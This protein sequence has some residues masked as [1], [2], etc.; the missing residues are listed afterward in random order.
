MAKPRVFVSSTYYDLKHVRTDLEH[1]IKKQGFEPVLHERGDIPYGSKESLE[2]YCYKEIELC[3]ILVSIIGGRFG[4][5][6]KKQDYSISNFELK[7]AIEM[8]KQ[9]YI[10]VYKD[11]FSEYQTYKIN[12]D[13]KGINY[14]AVDDPRTYTFLE[15]VNSLSL[16]NQI[17]EFDGVEDITLHLKAQWA[18]LFHRLLS[19]SMR[20][21]EIDLV[22]DLKNTS[23]T[24]K[25]LAEYL[26][27]EKEKGTQAVKDILLINHPAFREIQKTLE[28]PYRIVFQNINELSQHLK[29]IQ[30]DEEYSF[31]SSGEENYYNIEE[32]VFF[33][34]K[35]R[36][37]R[38]YFR[39]NKDIF[40]QNKK[41]K[42]YTPHEWNSDWIILD[43]EQEIP[44]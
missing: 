31:D 11:V 20:K 15:E 12:K 25:Y 4:A 5:E 34:W 18:G 43:E 2:E 14:A 22:D 19:A 13:N 24:L 6:S 28:I 16:N 33:S 9:V 32:I 26:V 23:M 38:T 30:F 7:T 35:K 10:F 36:N 3:D 1:F 8:E 40:D 39:I 37:E 41:I 21:K 17:K 44:F 42:I 27:N 29:A